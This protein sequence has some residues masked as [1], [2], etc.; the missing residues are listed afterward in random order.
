MTD[1]LPPSYET[2]NLPG[3]LLSHHP[4]SSSSPTPIVI[5]KIHRPEA[6]NAF[7]DALAAS[8]IR[9]FDLLS[10]DP[11]VRCVILTS[12]D[13]TNAFFCAGMDF[14]AQHAMGPTAATHRDEGGRVSLAIYRCAKPVIAA[15][16]G[17]AVGVGITMTL[18][19]S[20]RVVS[21]DAKIGFV[22]GRRGFT[23]EACSSFFLPRLLG[24]SRALH[25]V[26]TGAVYPANHRLLDGLFSEIVAPD[27]VL[28][29]AL[30]IAEDVVG[31]VSTVASTLMKDLMYRGPASP[32]EAHLLESRVFFDLIQGSD[33]EEGKQS[34]LQKRPPNF[35]GT[36][37]TDAPEV[38][39]WWPP[40]DVRR[41]EKL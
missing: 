14:G 26:T 39:P 17:S 40:I 28:P 32:E 13:S 41:R 6:R 34:F 12:S 31:N 18:P 37:A 5:V 24:T 23:M 7:T 33:A 1:Q 21:R 38:Y 4:P 2:L 10:A 25:L 30:R 16:N 27:D 20:I 19:A 22:F 35:T 29:A 11:R 9:A 36:M 15:I 3:L 8:L